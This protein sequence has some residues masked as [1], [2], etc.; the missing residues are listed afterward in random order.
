MKEI[1]HAQMKLVWDF[2]KRFKDLMGRLTFQIPDQEHQ[3]W[4]IGGL[5]PH[6]HRLLIQKM[7]ALQ[8]D[9]LEIAMKLESSLV[10]D[11]GGMAQ[12]KM[13]LDALNIQLEE[14]KKGNKKCEQVWHTKCRTEGHHKDEC[15]T[16]LQ[17]LETRVSNPL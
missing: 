17:Y 15:P 13:Y 2:D 4:F 6:I 11:S 12:V 9:A 7:I 5:L 16:F 14:I 3:E 1:K 8:P 10:G